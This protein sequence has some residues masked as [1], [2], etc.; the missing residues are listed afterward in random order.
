MQQ[1]HTLMQQQYL[2]ISSCALQQNQKDRIPDDY[3]RI[4]TLSVAIYAFHPAVHER[5]LTLIDNRALNID[6]MSYEVFLRLV[7]D[8]E[9]RP[10]SRSTIIA[11]TLSL[12]NKKSAPD[13]RTKPLTK[14]GSSKDG[15]L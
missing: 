12:F 1:L 11:F 2:K 6:V 15:D 4:R 13:S 8:A 5:L 9:T 10:S 14:D 3:E 7:F